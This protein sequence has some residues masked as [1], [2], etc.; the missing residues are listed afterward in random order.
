[1]KF[2][3]KCVLAI[4][5]I[6]GINQE[7]GAFTSPQQL[8]RVASRLAVTT[9]DEWQMLDNG[10]VVGSVKDH[11]SLNDGDIVTTSPLSNPVG[12]MAQSVVTTLTGSQ[13]ILGKP[14]ELKRPSSPVAVATA[15][16]GMERRDLGTVTTALAI[17][18]LFG[19]GIG[20]GITLT[21]AFSEKQMT[22]PEVS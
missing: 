18:G 13:Y 16:P 6:F 21:G 20:G 11:P 5:A 7:V 14:M 12:A 1:M 15:G 19:L 10:S 8:A 9:L 2:S 4:V 22:I 17:S 3:S